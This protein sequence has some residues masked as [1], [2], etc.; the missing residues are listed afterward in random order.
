MKRFLSSLNIVNFRGFKTF[1][2][3]SFR[4]ITIIGGKNNSGK[5]TLLE[6]VCFLSNRANGAIPGKLVWNR[7]EKMKG[8][9]L[10]TLFYGA[11]DEGEVSIH[12]IFSDETTRGVSFECTHRSA[13]EFKLEDLPNGGFNERLPFTYVQQFYTNHG[14]GKVSRGAMMLAFIKDEYRCYPLDPQKSDSEYLKIDGHATDD[15]WECVF[16]QSQRRNNISPVYAGIFKSGSEKKVLS[17]LRFVDS[18]IVDLAYDGEMLLV[19]VGNGNMRLP[20]SVMGDGMVKAA[21]ILSTLVMCPEGSI[22]CVDEIENGLHYSAMKELWK[23][24]VCLARDRNIQLIVTTHN[25]EILRA[26][27]EQ[28]DCVDDDEFVYLN[29][30]RRSDDN[31]VA[32]PYAHS[33][34]SH[35]LSMNLEVR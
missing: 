11:G 28:T 17:Y 10:A 1:T 6:A 31:V 22:L 35:S 20:I 3:D 34:L 18:R 15:D 2:C 19:G 9:S 26:I 14:E 16:Y 7:G 24:I 4:L 29:I 12:G 27:G 23:S 33:E 5:S 13:V 30:V 32:F 25:I 8:R 21:E